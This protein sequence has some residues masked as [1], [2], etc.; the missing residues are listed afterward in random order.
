LA[1]KRGQERG[2][3]C[4]KASNVLG[5]TLAITDKCKKENNQSPLLPTPS[6]AMSIL[7]NRSRFFL[8]EMNFFYVT[9]ELPP[10]ASPSF[11]MKRRKSLLCIFS[12]RPR[13]PSVPSRAVISIPGLN[14]TS[15]N[16]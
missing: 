9:S 5:L 12:P 11:L 6:L 4:N 10:I 7:I 15:A 3:L 16:D 14:K 8:I 1:E 2:L 13:F